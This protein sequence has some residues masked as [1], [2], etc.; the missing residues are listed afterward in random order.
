MLI[1]SQWLSA[2]VRV[3]KIPVTQDQCRL[4]M[5]DFNYLKLLLVLAYLAV[6]V[7]LLIYL[8]GNYSIRLQKLQ[9]Q[10]VTTTAEVRRKWRIQGKG[11]GSFYF[12]LYTFQLPGRGSYWRAVLVDQS[13]YNETDKGDA[14]PIKYI[15]D[16]PRMSDLQS[17]ISRSVEMISTKNNN[18]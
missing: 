17:N 14:V 11:K 8:F 6:P 10:G 3:T 7:I 5:T 16:N 18:R 2:D 15:P 13:V 4:R 1:R 12:F 9:R